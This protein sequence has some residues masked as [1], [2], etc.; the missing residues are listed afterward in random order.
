MQLP[1]AG[2]RGAGALSGVPG[3][4]GRRR[5]QNSLVGGWKGCSSILFPP[6]M[7]D[8]RCT[9]PF[10]EELMTSAVSCDRAVFYC[11]VYKNLPP[12][13]QSS[14]VP[15][16]CEFSL[17]S[18]GF[19]LLPSLQTGFTEWDGLLGLECLKLST[20]FFLLICE[21]LEHTE[22]SQVKFRWAGVVRPSPSQNRS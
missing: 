12:S 8:F 20:V 2:L 14:P 6:L 4:Q 3:R 9:V 7:W 16:F 17:A 19:P 21:C 11:R 22:T 13:S 10:L 15:Q 1:P 18:Q 5:V